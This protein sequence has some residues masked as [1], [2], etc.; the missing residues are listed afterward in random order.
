MVSKLRSIH[1]RSEEFIANSFL[2]D[3]P[4][5]YWPSQIALTTFQMSS[6]EYGWGDEF[7][8]YMETTFPIPIPSS[9]LS[10]I[11]HS[12]VNYNP[13]DLPIIKQINQRLS[14]CKN[15]LSIETSLVYQQHKQEMERLYEEK[16]KKKFQQQSVDIF[17]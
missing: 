2:T 10:Q 16:R 9:I 6:E 13:P 12:I 3:L 5:I 17:Q 7:A 14:K 1:Q 11:R 4:F 8:K 15:P